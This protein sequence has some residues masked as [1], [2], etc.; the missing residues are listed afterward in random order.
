[1]NNSITGIIII[2]IGFLI[3]YIDQYYRYESREKPKEKIIYKYIP[4][5]PQ[6]ELDEPVFVTDIFSTMFSQPDPWILDLNNLDTRKNDN[7]NKYFI[8]SV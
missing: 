2:L 7:I 4:K 5:S 6:E 3:L 8:S 1:M